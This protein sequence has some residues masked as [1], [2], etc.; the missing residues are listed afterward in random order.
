MW[1]VWAKK[2]VAFTPKGGCPLKRRTLWL[3]TASNQSSIHPQGWVPIETSHGSGYHFHLEPSVAFTPKGGCPLKQLLRLDGAYPNTVGSI[4]PQG[5]VPIETKA[6]HGN[7]GPRSFVAFTPKGG[8]PL[9]LS[10]CGVYS[11]SVD[12]QHSP[13]RVGAH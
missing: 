9:K 6:G 4:H 7:R 1:S 8:C 3:G 11:C 5:W 12:Q 2:T 13:P 10:D